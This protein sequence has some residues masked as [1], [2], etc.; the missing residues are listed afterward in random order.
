MAGF[1]GCLGQNAAVSVRL[2]NPND[3]LSN[4]SK[5]V[6]GHVYTGTGGSSLTDW[7]PAL[8]GTVNGITYF[9]AGEVMPYTDVIVIRRGDETSFQVQ[10]PA[11][12]TT[13]AAMQIPT[14][15]GLQVNDIIMVS[16]CKGGDVFQITD[17]QNPDTSGT[18]NHNGGAGTPGNVDQTLSR[19]YGTDSTIMKLVTRMY[20]ISKRG[21]S[22]TSAAA[23]SLPPALFRKELNQNA[24]DTQEL[25]EGI[26]RLRFSYGEDDGTDKVPNYYRAANSVSDWSKVVTVR[27]GVLSRTIGNVEAVSDTRTYDLAGNSVGPFNDNA[28]RRAFNSTIQLRNH[29]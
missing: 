16:D 12:G 1:S 8:P 14:S 2:N 3:Y 27:V 22:V 26:E 4:Y 9:S 20:Y 29:L 28:R 10:P 13:A 5:P 17:P 19:T 24:F 7:S 25:V 6:S 11:M 15:S 18:I 23:A 21:G